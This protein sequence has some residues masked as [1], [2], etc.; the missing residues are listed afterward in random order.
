MT[1]LF[2]FFYFLFAAEEAD[3]GGEGAAFAGGE[4]GLRM[5]SVEDVVDYERIAAASDV[6]ETTAEG[7]IVAEKMKAFFKLQ[8]EGDV[9]RKTLGA[10][11]ANELLLVGE[12][13]ER[14]SGAGFERVGD[15]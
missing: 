5:R 2:A 11:F 8:V 1:M 9:V 6:V 4:G 14:E 7:E 3:T 15:F 10:G 12:E 13:I